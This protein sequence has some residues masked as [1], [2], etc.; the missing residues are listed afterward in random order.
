MDIEFNLVDNPEKPEDKK[1]KFLPYAD[2]TMIYSLAAF[3][4]EEYNNFRAVVTNEFL[5]ALKSKKEKR[6]LFQLKK[7]IP[8]QT[9]N[10][11][12]LHELLNN[13]YRYYPMYSEKSSHVPDTQ[14]L[15]KQLRLWIEVFEKQ[16]NS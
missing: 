3:R 2:E 16:Q 7:E 13:L 14:K 8:E 6:I 9:E 4:P 11:R 5:K 15:L 12:S 10:Q 1:I